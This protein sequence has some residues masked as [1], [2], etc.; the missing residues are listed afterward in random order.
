MGLLDFEPKTFF[1][2][3]RGGYWK[4]H[5]RDGYNTVVP[6]WTPW[7][8]IITTAG[9]TA[10]YC[11]ISFADLSYLEQLQAAIP[12]RNEER[13]YKITLSTEPPP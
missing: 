5:F 8:Y 11:G 7:T 2:V 1:R 6:V 13:K 10:Q 4:L 9:F 3:T 12:L